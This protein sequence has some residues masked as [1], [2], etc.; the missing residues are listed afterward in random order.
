MA[1]NRARFKFKFSKDKTIF[2]IVLLSIIFVVFWH[3]FKNKNGKN[4]NF[5]NVSVSV[6]FID[7]G[8]GDCEL[9]MS[10]GHTVLIDA[11]EKD[12][13]N[14]VVKYLNKCGVKKLDYVIA[15][16]PHTD[17]IGGFSTVFNNV[18]VNTIVMPQISKELIPTNLTYKKFLQKIKEKN[19]NVKK[20]KV[21]DVF[22]LG[23]GV[24][25]ILGPISPN[26][27]KL[28]D[29]S[30][31]AIFSYSGFSFLFC[32]DMEK[33]AEKDLLDSGQKINADVFKLS[34][35]GSHTS[36]TK[37]FLEAV[38]PKYCIAEVGYKNSY[39]HPHRNVIKI[40][41]KLDVKRFFRTDRDG[42]I[43]FTIKDGKI[44]YKTEKGKE[45]VD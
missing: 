11:G 42:T 29:F 17:H 34:H 15:T 43:V 37:K 33:R 18:E 4:L 2:L 12:R 44:Y 45:A 13:G 14:F 27:E 31:G 24:L 25:N 32:G 8:Q 22:K 23:D 6:H 10:D 40:M 1:K 41:E 7:V 20:A 3:F 19:I 16:H 36:N 38:N 30:V 39:G 28:N 21:G 26:Y 9:I 5:K 35:H